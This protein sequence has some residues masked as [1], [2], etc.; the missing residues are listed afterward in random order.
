VEEKI[1]EQI[2]LSP[3][4]QEA[5]H[6]LGE[7]W[8]LF[9]IVCLFMVFRET[10]KSFVT[11]L[12]VL[13]SGTYE[14]DDVVILEGVPA[15]IVRMGIWKTTFYVYRQVDGG[16]L[17]HSTRDVMNEELPQLHIEIPQQRMDQ[18]IPDEFLGK[19]RERRN[20]L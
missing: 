15:R 2:T 13:R 7:L 11:S 17:F 5:M 1:E 10:I 8:W 19:P 20:D 9:I 12:M 3:F 16:K 18:L 6:V 14:V 4:A